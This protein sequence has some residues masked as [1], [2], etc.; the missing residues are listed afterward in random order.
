MGTSNRKFKLW[1]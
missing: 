1:A